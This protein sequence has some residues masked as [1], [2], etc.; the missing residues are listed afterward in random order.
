MSS[1]KREK[2]SLAASND[3]KTYANPVTQKICEMLLKSSNSN[4]WFGFAE[5]AIGA[6]YVF[7]EQPDV[8]CGNL[9]KKLAGNVFAVNSTT[10]DEIDAIA[11]ALSAAKINKEKTDDLEEPHPQ[12]NEIDDNI[13]SNPLELAQLIFVVG[14]V[15]IKQIVHL[16]N[17]E[18]EWKRR[19][20]V[21]DSGSDK[22]THGDLEMVAGSMEDEFAEK[23]N[24][25]RERELLYGPNS[26]LGIFGPII[27]HIC[28]QH[29]KFNVITI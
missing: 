28:L 15:A 29:Q 12:Q 2:G 1:T 19:K 11:T 5:Q 10:E 3:R 14:H 7:V 4:E 6:L 13:E 8:I 23:M 27:T 24:T 25:V 17:I 21:K 26:L 20:L 22:K 9:I 18:S 16:E